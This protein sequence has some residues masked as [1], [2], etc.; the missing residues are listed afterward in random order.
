MMAITC[1]SC[2][3]VINNPIRDEN[4][5]PILHKDLCVSCYKEL[6]IGVQDTM[7]GRRP[8][9]SLAGHKE[10]LVAQLNKM[11]R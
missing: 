3:R 4:Y 2:R 9:Y 7:E 11:T 6:R 8:H 1:D 5:Y 10:E